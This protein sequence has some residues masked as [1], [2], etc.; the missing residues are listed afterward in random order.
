MH[1]VTQTTLE[2]SELVDVACT[3]EVFADNTN[4]YRNFSQVRN[5]AMLDFSG[6][7][8]LFVPREMLRNSN[9]AYRR[10]LTEL[11]E[12]SLAGYAVAFLRNNVCAT[13][14]ETEFTR[15]S[16]LPTVVQNIVQCMHKLSPAP[17]ERYPTYL[18]RLIPADIVQMCQEMYGTRG[19]TPLCGY[20][21]Y[22][23]EPQYVLK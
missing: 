15:I 13:D 18:N 6:Q 14:D 19:E 5:T 10:M 9:D 3:D 21:L 7:T 1:A 4:R 16:Q 20:K 17:D 8:M 22:R 2:F 23:N 12:T 11:H